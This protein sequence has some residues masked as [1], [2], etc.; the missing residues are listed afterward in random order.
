MFE[1]GK[2]AQVAREIHNYNVVVLGLS[3]QSGQ[4]RLATG[5]MVLYSGATQAPMSQLHLK[6]RNWGKLSLLPI[7]AA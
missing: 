6:G 5:E 3:E 7:W 1:S 2:T 4:L